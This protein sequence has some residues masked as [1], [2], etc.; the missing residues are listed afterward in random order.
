MSDEKFL[1]HA[2][3]YRKAYLAEREAR[4]AAHA[5]QRRRDNRILVAVVF[6]LVAS[7]VMIGLFAWWVTS[8]VISWF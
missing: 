7:W 4:R 6:A 1:A 3:E 5:R 2:A 8:W